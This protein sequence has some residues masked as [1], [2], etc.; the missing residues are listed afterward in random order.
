MVFLQREGLTLKTNLGS[1]V[2]NRISSMFPKSRGDKVYNP[3]PKKGKSSSSP[4]E[5][6]TRG[7]C[8]KKNY[9]DRIKGKDNWF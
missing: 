3:K 4:I 2:S 5:K 8:S 7:K 1:R 9:G 6:P